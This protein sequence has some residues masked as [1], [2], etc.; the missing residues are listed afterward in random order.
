MT[1]TH[2][3][4][5]LQRASRLL[6]AVD[7]NDHN[8]DD[9]YNSK[10]YRRAADI[11]DGL[12]ADGTV[13]SW[14]ERDNSVAILLHMQ[15]SNKIGRVYDAV[16]EAAR[17]RAE[18]DADSSETTT[19]NKETTMLTQATDATIGNDT[20]DATIEAARRSPITDDEPTAEQHMLVRTL[21]NW[22]N[23]LRGGD[24][25]AA[26]TGDDADGFPDEARMREFIDKHMPAAMRDMVEVGMPCS[27]C[28]GSD[29]YGGEVVDV[30][31]SRKTLTVRLPNLGDRVFKQSRKRGS[32]GR[33]MHD[34]A[35]LV[36]GVA[37]DHRDPSF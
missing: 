16:F 31:A 33:Y 35:S 5:R 6:D 17:I 20:T 4:S 28:I 1:T 18:L 3:M 15:V 37:R 10:W 9:A 12:R 25:F 19:N 30:S 7:V 22:G 13:A 34:C 11:M 2:Y 32:V 14:N 24:L 29:S 23:S 26:L 8:L 27:L 21:A 36:L